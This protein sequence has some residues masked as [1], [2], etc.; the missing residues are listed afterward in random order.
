MHLTRILQLI[1]I[2][3]GVNLLLGGNNLLL[4]F[5]WHTEIN[6]LGIANL[7]LGILGWVGF[8]RLCRKRKRLKSE[9]Q[10]YE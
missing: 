2:V 10:I 6:L 3:S 7:A 8:A 4:F 9:Q 1:G 5:L